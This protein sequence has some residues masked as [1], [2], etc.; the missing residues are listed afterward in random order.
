MASGKNQRLSG[1]LFVFFKKIVNCG[2]LSELGIQLFEN[3]GNES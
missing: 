2:Y 3:N 1:Q